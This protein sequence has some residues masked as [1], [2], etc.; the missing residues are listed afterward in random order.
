MLL[1]KS[2]HSGENLYEEALATISCLLEA[3]NI[4]RNNI[5][6]LATGPR[7]FFRDGRQEE[8]IV[9]VQMYNFL[10]ELHNLSCNAP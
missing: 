1:K 2:E 10:H 6:T 7:E 4:A 5:Q 9:L 8:A 3:A